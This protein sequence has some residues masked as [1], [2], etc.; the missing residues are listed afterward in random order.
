M[1][2]TLFP[3]ACHAHSSLPLLGSIADNFDDWLLDRGYKV[4]SRTNAIEMLHHIDSDLRR[5]GI[6]HITR[7]THGILHRSWRA[8]IPRFP[9]WASTVRVLERYLK[10]RGL[11][12]EDDKAE[13]C[14]KIDVQIT[15]YADYLQEVR[16]CAQGTICAHKRIAKC[17]LT[18]LEKKRRQL[19][20]LTGGD[21]EEYIKKAG[22]RLSRGSLQNEAGGLR[23]FLR[24]LASQKRIQ[25]GLDSQIDTPRL[26]RLEHLPRSLPWETVRAFLQ[27]ID[28]TT[29]MG[30]RDYTI[31][32][33]IATYGL[34]VSEAVAL[35]LEGIQWR[36]NTI[37]VFQ[38]KASTLLELPL[39]NEVGT[40]LLKYL[41]RVP[42]RPLYRQ[43][44][45]RMRAPIGP[46]TPD[47]VK[48]AFRS[49]SRRSDLGIPSQGPHCMRHAYAVNLL[50]NGTA[51]KTI[52]DILGHR[53]AES[54]VTYL[55]LA[56]DD[57]RDVA[58]SVPRMPGQREVRP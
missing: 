54:T 18:Y 14:S 46:L 34:R 22:K 23:S 30:L 38:P 48:R 52:G 16:G 9:T 36:A 15:A 40:A 21:L 19:Q 57:L 45:L 27:S 1:L 47:A 25:S 28:R 41:K 53:C 56:T 50:K 37:K 44:F 39:T 13:P 7:L 26:Y 4:T 12:D 33:L 51:L 8:L 55:R 6:K 35:T 11:L 29:D 17:F 42:P 3:K 5:R 32:L 49:W 24:F 58:L 2:T 43:I 31:F 20:A 10:T